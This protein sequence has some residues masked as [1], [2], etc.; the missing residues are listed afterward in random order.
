MSELKCMIRK[1]ISSFKILGSKKLGEVTGLLVNERPR[2][3]DDPFLLQSIRTKT[4]TTETKQASAQLLD[5]TTVTQPP[6]PLC[7]NRQP[8]RARPALRTFHPLD[9]LMTSLSPTLLPG[10]NFLKAEKILPKKINTPNNCPI[11]LP[12][13]IT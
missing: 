13:W 11:L 8:R 5:G 3:N 10:Y 6:L 12:I 9:Y 2:M 7:L 1:V 4:L